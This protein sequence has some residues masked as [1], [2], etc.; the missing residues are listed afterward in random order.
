MCIQVPEPAS[1]GI[2]VLHAAW[3]SWRAFCSHK[4]AKR[5]RAQSAAAYLALQLLHSAFDAWRDGLEHYA[6]E[7]R[8]LQRADAWSRRWW[9]HQARV[10]KL[11]VRH[12]PG[13]KRVAKCMFGSQG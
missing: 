9:L 8:A 6:A 13:V 11:C 12:D 5:A 7:R 3:R 4:A 1:S 10:H 2:Q